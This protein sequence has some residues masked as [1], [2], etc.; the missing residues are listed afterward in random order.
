MILDKIK[1]FFSGKKTPGGKK[2]HTGVVKRV[3]H[4]KG[5]GFIASP[6]FEKQVFVH[7]SNTKTKLRVGMNVT[8]RVE[9]TEKGLR[10]IDVESA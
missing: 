9:E 6:D 4:N 5:Y 8:F 1:A 3:T 2:T 7:F 10:A